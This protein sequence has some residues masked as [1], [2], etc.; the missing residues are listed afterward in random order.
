M[1]IYFSEV[2]TAVY[3]ITESWLSMVTYFSEVNIAVCCI[4]ESE[5]FY[6]NLL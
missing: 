5:I 3:Y 6:G 4:T 1:A 2:N